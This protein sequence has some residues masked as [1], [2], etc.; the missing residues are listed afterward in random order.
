MPAPHDG[1][2]SAAIRVAEGT[3]V[4]RRDESSA[5]VPAL[6]EAIRAAGYDAA[7]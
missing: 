5:R 7:R 6:V 2:H 4:V 3:I 1:V